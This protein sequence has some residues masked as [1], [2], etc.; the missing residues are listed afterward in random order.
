[1]IENCNGKCDTDNYNE[2]L[3]YLKE[4]W[5]EAKTANVESFAKLI[6]DQF[7]KLEE[8]KDGKGVK[9]S[10]FEQGQESV[11]TSNKVSFLEFEPTTFEAFEEIE[12]ETKENFENTENGIDEINT[13]EKKE[14]ETLIENIVD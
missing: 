7:P 5:E 6:D 1:M 11:N 10:N 14:N 3:D 9:K 12:V 4:V 2:I 8:N 13:V